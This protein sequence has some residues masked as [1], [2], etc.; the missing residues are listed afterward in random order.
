MKNKENNSPSNNDKSNEENITKP[1]SH[2]KKLLTQVFQKGNKLG[3]GRTV[4]SRNKATIALEMIGE[5][6]VEEILLKTIELA[7]SGDIA[8]CKLIL[9]RVYKPRKGFKWELE[10]HSANTIQEVEKVSMEV[11]EELLA[12]NLTTEEANLLHDTLGSRMQIIH[13][14]QIEQRLK[15]LEDA[16]NLKKVEH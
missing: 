1:Q 6:H 14:T 10:S 13:D 15:D 3:K 5:A 16:Y 12:G 9:D 7:K 2:K 4:G 8:A 11:M